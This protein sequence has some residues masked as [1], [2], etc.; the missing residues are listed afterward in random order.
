VLD[1]LERDPAI[2]LEELA[3]PHLRGGVVEAVVVEMPVH[4]IQPWRDPAAARFEERDAQSRVTIDNPAPD[5]RHR[6]Q[7]HLHRV[8]DHVARGAVALEAVDADS[9]D[10]KS[11]RLNSSHRTISY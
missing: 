8:A 2:A 7:H 9:G 4:S 3:R 10:R 6:R 11:T 5:H 1:R